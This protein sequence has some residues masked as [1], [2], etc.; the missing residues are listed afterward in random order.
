M[1]NKTVIDKDKE[2]KVYQLTTELLETQS[3]QK[4]VNAGYRDEVKRLRAEIKDLVNPDPN[5]E[6]V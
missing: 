1:E 4:S 3:K 5:K 6:K 2:S